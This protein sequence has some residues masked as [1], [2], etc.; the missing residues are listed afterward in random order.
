MS[1][2][3]ALIDGNAGGYGVA[4]PDC[5]GCT[6]MAATV[7]EAISNASAA[8][9]EWVADELADGRAAPRPRSIEEVR[10]DADVAEAVRGGA[11]LTLVPLVMDSGKSTRANLSL[12]AG[13]LAAIDEAAAASGTTRSAF[14][15]AAARAKIAAGG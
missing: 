5:P 14:L 9:A 4:F 10:G 2:Y 1:R 6:A 7:E 8:L 12:D 15:A 11:A 13:L 3:A